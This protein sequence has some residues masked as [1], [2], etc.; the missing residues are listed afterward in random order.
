MH[1]SIVK[2]LKNLGI[3]NP[4]LEIP[5]N[6]EMGDYA[7]PCFS[8][9]KKFRKSPMEIAKDLASKIKPSKD[10]EKIQALGA[11]VNFFIDKSQRAREVLKKI[12]KEKD[13]YGSKSL[14]K[15]KKFLIEHTSINPNASPHLGRA[16][17]A[18]LGDSI[19]RILKF[20]GYK[21]EVH[22]FVNDVGKQIALL[23]LGCK[24]KT[25]FQDLLKIYIA[26]NKKLESNPSIEEEVFS[27]LK[28]FE[29]GDK[30]TIKRFKTTVD[31]CIKG[32]KSILE[33][34]GITY[35]YFD[36]ESKYL[37]NKSTDKILLDLKK[38]KK[39]FVDDN[40]RLV[41]NQEGLELPMESSFLVLTRKDN[42]SLYPLRDLAYTI[43]KMKKSKN[44]LL[45]LGEDQ[46]LYFQ[47]LKAALA[48]LKKPHPEVIHYSYVLLVSGKKMSTRK[49]NLVLL[50][51]FLKEAV[52]KAEEK[53]NKKIAREVANA[54]IK[55]SILKVSCDKNVV[56]DW[57]QALSFEGDTGPYLQYTYAR[58]SS[59]L[60]K[61]KVS[62]TVDFSLL[63]EPVEIELIKKLESF[64]EVVKKS[65][66]TYQPHLI[67]AYVF[68]LC[69][70]FNE[71]YHKYPV[72][73]AEHNLRNSRLCLVKAFN[74]TARNALRLLGITP[75]EKM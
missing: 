58:S 66:L 75:L 2:I 47:Q 64:P 32:Q 69:Q 67:A 42:T 21:T 40:S 74:Q 1:T 51:D 24:Q 26:M 22:Y 50:E 25:K 27:L 48:L 10:I 59:I 7:F 70:D 71:F 43:E 6:P 36:Y 49:G 8:L 37:F 68:S 52:K 38:T 14:G 18:L 5:P 46:K 53:S 29:E 65:S 61:S 54:A 73:N 39:L 62:T 13:K 12:L 3:D 41:L 60:R 56:F 33:E 31:I 19:T 9:A 30:K 20:Q 34:M 44:N 57:T 4:E 63:R 16:R 35:D 28:K 55:Y 23:V 15:N 11:Y 45:V 72:I 17:N